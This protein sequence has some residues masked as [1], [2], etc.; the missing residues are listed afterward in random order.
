MDSHMVYRASLSSSSY[1]S[2]FAMLISD[3]RLIAKS[4]FNIPFCFVKRSGLSIWE[5]L[6]PDFLLSVLRSELSQVNEGFFYPKKKKKKVALN[7]I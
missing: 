3:C 7:S 1:S 6:I 4:L 2:P 5:A